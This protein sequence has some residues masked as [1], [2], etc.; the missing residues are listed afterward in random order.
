MAKKPSLDV[1]YALQS[2]DDNRLLYV[3]WAKTYDCDFAENMG[4][5][6]P[7]RVADAFAA[8]LN[9]SQ[10][11]RILDVGA[12]TGLVGQRL[13][14]HDYSNIDGLDISPE[15]LEVARAKGCYE[16]MIEGDL[17]SRLLIPDNTYNY[18][19][20][21]GTFTHGHVGA[22]ALDELLRI[23]KPGALFC[24]AINSTYFSSTGFE[25]K[26]HQLSKKITQL[27]FI[28]VQIYFEGDHTD[29]EGVVAIFRSV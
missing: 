11:G 25:K 14:S 28:T 20:S 8:K 18:I 6:L 12:G 29:G 3:D 5:A 22:S 13:N 24:I 26:F 17:L 7:I 23:S 16:N 2:P 10:N 27:E 19:I 21:A 9:G 15:M 1:A 4:Y